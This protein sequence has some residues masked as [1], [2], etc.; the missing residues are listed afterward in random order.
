MFMEEIFHP[1]QIVYSLID[2]GKII[3]ILLF[4]AHMVSCFIFLISKDNHSEV[5]WISKLNYDS[6]P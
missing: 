3:F 2:I 6:W 1:R 5:T 4:I